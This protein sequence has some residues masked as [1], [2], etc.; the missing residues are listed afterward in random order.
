MSY[1]IEGTFTQAASGQIVQ[2]EVLA[3]EPQNGVR[4][5]IA[6]HLAQ[7]SERAGFAT[8]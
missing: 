4:Q 3:T 2:L 6:G 8:P 5:D 1:V 7:E